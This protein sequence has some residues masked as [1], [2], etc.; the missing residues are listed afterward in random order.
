M[1]N[2]AVEQSNSRLVGLVQHLEKRIAE[3]EHT[4][5]M[6]LKELV[7]AGNGNG[8]TETHPELT[9]DSSHRR[10]IGGSSRN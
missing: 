8:E 4:A 9:L 7:D 6:P 3:L 2:G 1:S 5:T 10:K